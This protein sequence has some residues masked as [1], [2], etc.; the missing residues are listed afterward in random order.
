MIIMIC[1]VVPYR[2]IFATRIS[3]YMKSG[4]SCRVIQEG[5]FSGKY[6]HNSALTLKSQKYKKQRFSKTVQVE[7]QVK[8]ECRDIR[9]WSDSPSWLLFFLGF[10]S[11][12]LQRRTDALKQCWFINFQCCKVKFPA[13]KAVKKVVDKRCLFQ[14]QRPLS[15]ATAEKC[16]LL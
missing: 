13:V 7:V 4:Q 5:F 11:G 1:D 10:H 9:K 16:L 2:E 14:S 12:L 8:L 15:I 6:F 3:W